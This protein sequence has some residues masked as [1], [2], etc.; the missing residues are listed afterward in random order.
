MNELA[1]TS[2]LF[3]R[4]DIVVG[5]VVFA[6]C[7]L[8][9]L[10]VY[11]GEIYL[12]PVGYAYAQQALR[13]QA[14]QG[15]GGYYESPPGYAITIVPFLALGLTTLR[16]AWL[17]SILSFAGSAG[18][19]YL[20]LRRWASTAGALLAVAIFALNPFSLLTASAAGS[21]MLCIL[22]GIAGCLLLDLSFYET[23][24]R[25]TTA[26]IL[27]ALSGLAFAFSFAVRYL[28]IIFPMLGFLFAAVQF[29]RHPD[30][31][32]RST[33]LCV[34]A[35]IVSAMIPLRNLLFSGKSLTG[36]V[37][38][39]VVGQP[40][41]VSLTDSLYQLGGGWLWSKVGATRVFIIPVTLLVAAV[42]IIQAVHM[43]RDLRKL[44][45]GLVPLV[46][47]LALSWST[48]ATRLDAIGPRYVL[49]AFPFLI[50][51]VVLMSEGM[52]FTGAF[53]TVLHRMTKGVLWMVVGAC[54][55][56]SIVTAVVGV[57]SF[58]MTWN[59]SPVTIE[60]VKSNIPK[61]SVIA[62]NRFGDQLGAFTLDV[63]FFDIPFLD[64]WNTGFTEG[65]GIKTL[66]RKELLK[67]FAERNVK[68]LIFFLGKTHSDQYLERGLYGEQISVMMKVPTP[69]VESRIDLE[70][71]VVLKI[72]D[73]EKLRSI[74][75]AL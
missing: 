68:Y 12:S 32:L 65:W 36:H 1:S 39:N 66:T 11:K 38:N 63:E 34:M 71:G 41:Y 54:T 74:I 45:I 43:S 49:P 17:V 9:L 75:E 62:A 19:L 69:E 28:G 67:L 51:G 55:L 47:V 73:K 57:G 56:A 29:W 23:R 72:A 60:Y 52:L 22:M 2:A 26:N 4:R 13:I 14:G 6:C 44:I 8:A 3:P 31:R 70:D 35:G 27:A 24:Q 61:G 7:I 33:L 16:G 25:A 42:L 5:A 37:I 40:F 48:S 15:L 46:Y 58:N 50:M 59:L 18:V 10:L 64:P 53:N 21:E 20:L 30:M